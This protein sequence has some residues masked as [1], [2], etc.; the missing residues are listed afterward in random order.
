[1]LLDD[2]FA[3][4]LNAVLWG[5]AVLENIRKFL[6]FQLVVNVTACVLTIVV[7][8]IQGGSVT[9]FPLTPIQLLYI[10]LIMDSLAALALATEPPSPV[11]LKQRPAGRT[12][13]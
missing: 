3:S 10:N 5:R 9:N 13:R 8:C 1:M 7:A 11:L 4:V 12:E 2:N 6:S